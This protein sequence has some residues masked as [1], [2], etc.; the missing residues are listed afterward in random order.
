[1]ALSKSAVIDGPIP[2]ENWTSDPK[3]YPWH[4]APDFV[5]P[6]PAMEY[7]LGTLDDEDQQDAYIALLDMG[8]DVATITDLV[9]TKGI[10]NGK[11]SIDLGMLLAGPI[12]HVIVLLARGRGESFEM[13]LETES[14]T[15][16]KAFFDG[17]KDVMS[18]PKESPPL[19][20]DM[21]NRS[22][23]PMPPMGANI[24]TPPNAPPGPPQGA[25]GPSAVGGMG[26]LA[27]P[28]VEAPMG[29]TG[30]NEMGAM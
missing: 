21:P 1:M 18:R 26:F 15:P 10:E 6:D 13:G 30:P 9:V 2:G 8:F 22:N 24:P 4:R 19:P 25:E 7:F 29:P 28:P 20:E 3:D 27:K 23:M 11:W 5:D 12:S 14:Q 17:L 16:S